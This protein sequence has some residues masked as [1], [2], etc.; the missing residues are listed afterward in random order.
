MPLPSGGLTSQ[1]PHW[2]IRDTNQGN[3]C[4]FG[5]ISRFSVGMQMDYMRFTS[6]V[7]SKLT[8]MMVDLTCSLSWPEAV[9]LRLEVA[10]QRNYLFSENGSPPIL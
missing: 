5:R 2:A 8:V 10:S 6:N 1:I 7:A 3:C 9:N 4:L